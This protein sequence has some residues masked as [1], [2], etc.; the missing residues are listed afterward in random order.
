MVLRVENDFLDRALTFRTLSSA[1]LNQRDG[2]HLER[3]EAVHT[4]GIMRLPAALGFWTENRRLAYLRSCSLTTIT[5]EL[6][7][8]K[9]HCDH[10]KTTVIG[11]DV[12]A[13]M[14]IP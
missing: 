4:G 8:S 3:F 5:A 12:V 1:A 11:V 7:R 9:E 2:T 14:G 13:A 10:N 6:H